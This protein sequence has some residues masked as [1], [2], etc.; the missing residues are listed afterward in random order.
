M[1][2]LTGAVL[3]IARAIFRSL[4]LLKLI[5][6]WW[7]PETTLVVK[8]LEDLVNNYNSQLMRLLFAS[9]NSKQ[10]LV[11]VFCLLHKRWKCFTFFQTEKQLCFVYL[12]V[13]VEEPLSLLVIFATVFV[14]SLIYLKSRLIFLGIAMDV[15]DWTMKMKPFQFRC[16]T[17][18]LWRM[19]WWLVNAK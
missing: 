13:P 11:F 18:S 4:V 3:R 16:L 2:I 7:V 5:C 1:S 9:A 10:C 6:Y 12:L 14:F 17:F 8:S 19:N 15:R